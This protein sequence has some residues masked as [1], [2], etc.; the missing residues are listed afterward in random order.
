MIVR[1]P[2][3]RPDQPSGVLADFRAELTGQSPD[4]KVI[5]WDTFNL[6]RRPGR[7]R[8]WMSAQGRRSRQP[9]RARQSPD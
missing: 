7:T 3:W 2:L 5:A 8:Q 6:T 9:V 4:T 1:H